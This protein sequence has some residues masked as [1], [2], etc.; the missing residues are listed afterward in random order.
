MA[1]GVF[2]GCGVVV[3]AGDADGFVVGAIKA[4]F[5]KV[6]VAVCVE[7]LIFV[8]VMIEY[9][10]IIL[11]FNSSGI[12]ME[13]VPDVLLYCVI[14]VSSFPSESY[15]LKDTESGVPFT[16]RVNSTFSI[17]LREMGAARRKSAW[18]Y[19]EED[20]NSVTAPAVPTDAFTLALVV[21][22]NLDPWIAFSGIWDGA[23]GVAV[24]AVGFTLGFTVGG[25]VG[26]FVGFEVGSS[27]ETAGGAAVGTV[28]FTLGF[29]VGGVVGFSVGSEV[30]SSVETAGGAAVGSDDGFTVGT[31]VSVGFLGVLPGSVAVGV[32]RGT[33]GLSGACVAGFADGAAVLGAGVI[34]LAAETVTLQVRVR[35]VVLFLTVAVIF[36][37]P[38][39]FAVIFA[40][41]FPAF[42]TVA[43]FLFLLFQ[44]IFQPLA[45]F[46]ES[47]A[48]FPIFTESFFCLKPVFL[49][50]HEQL[51][52]LVTIQCSLI[53]QLHIQVM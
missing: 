51:W 45:R 1:V 53:M 22:F 24:G 42:L 6:A 46:T 28:G 11:F 17:V 38:F 27:V 41:Y 12:F 37:E 49:L 16:E 25:V 8:F 2:A 40:A 7:S 13:W 36:T 50:L 34:L 47:F 44:E 20:L 15:N 39:F 5:D 30:G 26:F 19:W 10:V 29:T 18:L 32:F 3:G 9:W 14:L 23:K 35:R 33:S 52:K 43:I 4:S 31:A 21:P 48:V